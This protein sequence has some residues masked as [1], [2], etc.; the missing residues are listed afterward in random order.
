MI[1]PM[2]WVIFFALLFLFGAGFIYLGITVITRA[3]KDNRG[4]ICARCKAKNMFT[5]VY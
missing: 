5:F 4:K 2:D 3:N 1:K